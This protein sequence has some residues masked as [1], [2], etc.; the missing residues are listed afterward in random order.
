[1][2]EFQVFKAALDNWWMD[3]YSEPPFIGIKV[4]KVDTCREMIINGLGY[5]IVPSSL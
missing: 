5:A 3:N 1:M 2:V 4:D